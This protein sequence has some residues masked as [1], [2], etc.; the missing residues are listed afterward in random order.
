MRK[1][2]IA[3]IIFA[4]GYGSRMKGFYGNKTLLPLIPGARSYE[5]ER[6]LI[7]EVIKNLPTGPKALVLNYRK[8]EV[9]CATRGKDIACLI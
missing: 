5:G 6:P 1:K 4:A 7:I 2:G 3:S 8:D 9:I